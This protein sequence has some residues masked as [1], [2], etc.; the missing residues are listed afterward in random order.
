MSVKPA[1]QLWSTV[2]VLRSGWHSHMHARARPCPL[3]YDNAAF[4]VRLWRTKT[5]RR[6]TTSRPTFSMLPVP[7]AAARLL[8]CVMCTAVLFGHRRFYE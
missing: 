1:D 7:M 4:R 8:C 2:R 6:S 3:C 5:A